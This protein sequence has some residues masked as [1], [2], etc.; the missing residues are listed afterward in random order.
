MA[1]QLGDLGEDISDRTLVLNV[2]RGLNDQYAAL[3]RQLRRAR[4]FPTFLEV[5]DDLLLEELTASHQVT[6]PSTALLTGTSSTA[7]QLQQSLRSPAPAQ[8]PP[9]RSNNGGGG[10]G[11]GKGGGAGSSTGASRQ[12]RSKRAGQ[13]KGRSGDQAS[14]SKAPTGG[15]SNSG[16]DQGAGGPWPSFNP[17]TGTINMYPSPRP[18]VAQP[19][20]AAL[21]QALMA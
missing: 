21:R 15:G 6:A 10:R 3:G 13:G 11:S 14:S 9:A 1:D 20:P 2:L 8:Q 16:T 5:R 7:P 12:R 4:P 17:W 18:P 19:R